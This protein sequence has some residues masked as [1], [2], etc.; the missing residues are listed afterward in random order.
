MPGTCFKV[1]TFKE[2]KKKRLPTERHFVN[3]IKCYKTVLLNSVK[4]V[5]ISLFWRGGLGAAM[6]R[7]HRGLDLPSGLAASVG[8]GAGNGGVGEP[9]RNF[10]QHCELTQ[11]RR[12]H[13][14]EGTTKCLKPQ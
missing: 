9:E 10:L 13:S 14:A 3:K 4:K 6:V 11:N 12:L 1:I 8:R 7:E 2:V 5:L